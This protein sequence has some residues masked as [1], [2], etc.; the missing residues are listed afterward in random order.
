MNTILITGANGQLGS[1][2]KALS[3]SVDQLEFLFT[4]IDNLDITNKDKLR[5]FYRQNQ[6]DCIVNC[7]AYT[8]VDKA[9][10]DK[11]AAEKVNIEAVRNLVEL[12]EENNIDLIH[13][14]T[15]YVFDGKNY[16]PYCEDDPVNPQSVYGSTKLEGDNIMSN[17]NI[18]AMIIRTSWLYSVY[19]KNFVKTMLHHGQQKNVMNVVFDQVG[20][21]T[22]A[23]D[24]ATVII[25]ILK[26]RAEN[27]SYFKQGIYHF[28]NEGVCSWYDF[29]IEIF[30]IA[31]INC[32]VN[33]IETKDYPTVAK[34]P[35]YSVLNKAKIK[36]TF[37]ITIPH[38]KDSLVD[39]L[40]ILMK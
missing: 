16:K 14:S 35:H 5:N 7:A 6:F 19:G 8:A 21:P 27:A 9:E 1:E 11:S 38:W 20:S 24:F 13:T 36:S 22:N 25:R 2:I 10:S 12:A 34:R 18:N 29:A 32:S 37:N 26:Q 28:S 40:S 17:S 15:D 4:D 23:R 31:N 30:R 3:K 33:P 39:C